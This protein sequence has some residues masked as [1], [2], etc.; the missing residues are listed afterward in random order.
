MALSL[1][2]PW[3]PEA[4]KDVLPYATALVGFAGGLVTAAFRDQKVISPLDEL[5][6]VANLKQNGLL[7]DE[8][9]QEFKAKL[10]GRSTQKN[11]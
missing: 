4:A 10:I 11:E 5:Q 7:S 6:K 9:V 3:R 8:E 2:A 1:W